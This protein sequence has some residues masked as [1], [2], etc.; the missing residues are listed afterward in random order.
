MAVNP[1][2]AFSDGDICEMER[3]VRQGGEVDS[4][5]LKGNIRNA[6]YLGAVFIGDRMVGVGAIK[7]LGNHHRT[8]IRRSGYKGLEGLSA[9]IG[10]FSLLSG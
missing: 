2:Q 4:R 7:R 1:P 8:I 6:Y 5:N 10:Y 3:L 9:E